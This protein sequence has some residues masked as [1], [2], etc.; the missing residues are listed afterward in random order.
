MANKEVSFEQLMNAKIQWGDIKANDPKANT[1]K[2]HVATPHPLHDDKKVD[3]ENEEMLEDF[4]VPDLRLRKDIYTRF[5]VVLR[6]FPSGDGVER[7][8]IEWDSRKY[9]AAR[10]SA[11]SKDEYDDFD[12]YT[13]WRLI[14]SLRLKHDLYTIEPPRNS[15]E[16]CV[17]AMKP[18]PVSEAV[19]RSTQEF[20]LSR[21]VNIPQMSSSGEAAAAASAAANR[22]F[23]AT[24]AGANKN[25]TRNNGKDKKNNKNNKHNKHNTRRNN[26][27]RRVPVVMTLNDLKAMFPVVWNHDRSRNLYLLDIHNMNA[28]AEA[29]RLGMNEDMYKKEMGGR[30]RAV[31][32][33]SPAWT[34]YEPKGDNS[35]Y[36]AVLQM[37]R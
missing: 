24:K 5:P 10:Q 33:A 17:I 13:V 4:K 28:K 29:M 19:I 7:Y 27:N 34:V 36:F 11:D 9:E 30:L 31:L 16:I 35:K 15:K 20:M 8:A 26:I 14:Y 12:F 21:H 2:K 3:K 18:A 6:D 25:K 37:R 1:P 32:A 23:H 22:A